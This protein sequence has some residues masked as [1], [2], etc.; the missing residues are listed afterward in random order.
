MIFFFLERRKRFSH[1]PAQPL[2]QRII[3]ALDMRGFARLLAN[4]SVVAAKYIFVRFLKISDGLCMAIRQWDVFFE[5]F[6]NIDA[7]PTDGIGPSRAMTCW[8]YFAQRT[9][10]HRVQ[11]HLRPGRVTASHSGWASFGFFY[12]VGN[13]QAVDAK[14][15]LKPA[16]AGTLQVGAEHLIAHFLRVRLLRVESAVALELIAAIIRAAMLDFFDGNGSE[17]LSVCQRRHIKPLQNDKTKPCNYSVA[18]GPFVP[19][20]KSVQESSFFNRR[21]P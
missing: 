19:A 11:V 21:S 3:S 10:L 9:R 20:S 17:L 4:V 7:A 16:Y 2:A 5:I 14:Y 12:P 8:L 6:K 13:G 1:K 15:T 18:I